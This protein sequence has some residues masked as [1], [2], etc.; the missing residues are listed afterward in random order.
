V[1]ALPSPETALG[2]RLGTERR[3]ARWPAMV[4]YFRSLAARSDRIRFEELG[5]ATGGQPLILLTISSP[6]NLGRLP[7]LR[8]IQRQLA[9]PRT[10]DERDRESLIAEGRC[11]CLMTCSIHATEVG[12][13]QMAPDLV[14]RL[15]VSE[16]A[17]ARR[18]RSEVVLLLMPSLNPDGLE[19][20]ADWYE[21]TLGTTHEGSAP[22]ELYHPFAGHD[23]NRDWF[24]QTLVET[25]LTVRHVHNR[26]RPQIVFDLHQMQSN[27]PRYVLPPF[28]DPYDP[29]VDPLLQAN[30]NA[31][32]TSIA[33]ELT[34]QGKSGVATSVIFDAYSPSRAYSHYHG[35]V[36]I[37]AEAASARIASPVRLASDQLVETRG[38]DPR[39]AAHNHPLPWSGG[40]WALHDIV[41]Y[42]HSAAWALLDHTAR[43][44]DR[45]LRH[46]AVVQD[47]G[48]AGEAPAA[49]V[50]PPLDHQ[51]DPGTAAE[52]IAVLRAGD[53]EVGQ[54]TAPFV[55]DGIES[56]TGTYVVPIAQPF[57]RFAQTLLEVQRYPHLPL[58]PGGPPRP[59]YDI[60]AHTLPLQ[61]GV[62][63]VPVAASFDAALAPVI[64]VP[65]V[66][67]GLR[68]GG[69]AADTF[70]VPPTT[71]RAASLVNRLLEQGARIF[72]CGA[73]IEAAGQT[74]PPG[75]FVVSR[76]A[77]AAIDALAREVGVVVRGVPDLPPARLRR[78]GSPRVGLY[79]SWRPNAI[80]EGWTRYVLTGYGFD[81]RPLRDREVRQGNLR[82]SFDAIVL[83]QQPPRDILEGNGAAEYPAEF[84]GG[85]GDLGVANL[86]RFVEEGGTLVA[87]DAACDVA[88]KHFYL[89]VTNVVEGLRP[90]EFY[91][92]GSLLR[93]LV[94]PAHPVAWG[95]PRESVAM[96]VGSP[97]FDARPGRGAPAR[98]V[99]R[100]PLSNPLL[101]GWITGWEVISGRAAIVEAPL[102]RGRVVLIGIRPQFRAQARATYRLLF[103]ALYL[104]TLADADDEG[105]EDR[106][107][108]FR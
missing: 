78:L 91:A 93:L 79:R 95:L 5:A 61:M 21:R 36:R 39:L 72:R 66:P 86:R 26:W 80:D 75:S 9:D 2:F 1:L 20:V 22:P 64:E 28:V 8:E 76:V 90:E 67:G 77:P 31:L 74:M 85:M 87:L 24:M 89:P 65:T 70:V 104:S 58:C 105:R 96:F 3:L 81:H 82:A 6:E 59:P 97:A 15:V 98:I 108:G 25:R 94:D 49:F 84:A 99:A 40:T 50:I 12:A 19:L 13:S 51:P 100:Y 34:A 48:M 18:I 88:I 4:D 27:G 102:G 83:A 53:V 7:R 47:R 45:W 44:R 57:G 14:H 38:F 32:G 30:V 103:N 35:G 62:D 68:F 33:A 55:A 42:H 107:R 73:A 106:P 10:R 23:N 52:L 16:D 101:S 17:E 92:P 41:A 11:V 29:N 60:T 71:N 63:A 46:F 43:F 54:A 69:A 37:L 56:P